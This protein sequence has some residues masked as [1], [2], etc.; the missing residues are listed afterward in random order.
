MKNKEQRKEILKQVV[1]ESRPKSQAEL[2]A[3]LARAG[4][5]CTQATISRDIKAY[6]LQKD[7]QG[8]YAFAEDIRLRRLFGALSQSM[9][10]AQNQV[11]I[12][13]EP[14]TAP[15]VAAAIDACGLPLVVGSIAGDDTILLI[16]KDAACAEALAA[17]LERF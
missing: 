5:D 10:V 13:T 2:L 7:E 12:K 14:G 6:G 17:Q 1:R 4:V 15:G 8:S 11:V 9:V 16:C 3:A